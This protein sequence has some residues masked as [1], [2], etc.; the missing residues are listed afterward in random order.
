MRADYDP[1]VNGPESE[2]ATT[3]ATVVEDVLGS[4]VEMTD[5]FFALGGSSLAALEVTSRLQELTGRDIPLDLLYD[6]DSL[7]DFAAAVRD[8]PMFATPA[9]GQ[10]P[11]P[12]GGA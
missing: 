5:N 7:A 4:A 8:C 6:A 2:V 10:D 11:E 9:V 3:V 12:A 1:P